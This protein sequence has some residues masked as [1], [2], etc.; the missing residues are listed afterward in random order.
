MTPEPRGLV[1]AVL[2]LV[3]IFLPSM[4][5]VVGTLPFWDALRQRAG[6]RSALAGINAAVVG[7]LLAALYHPVWTGAILRPADFGVGLAAFLLFHLWRLPP[8]A[9]VVLSACAGAAL[10]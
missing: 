2:C 8:W 9:V 4:L 6:V 10:G 1:G 7:L 5:L 3:A